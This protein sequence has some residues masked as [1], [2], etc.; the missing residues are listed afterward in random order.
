M[1]NANDNLVPNMPPKFGSLQNFCYSFPVLLAA[2][3][4]SCS[5]DQKAKVSQVQL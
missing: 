3:L 5:E 1:T 2:K 4:C